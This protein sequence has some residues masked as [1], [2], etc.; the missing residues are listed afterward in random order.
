M[1]RWAVRVWPVGGRRV[2]P[3]VLHDTAA[4]CWQCGARSRTTCRR[5]RRVRGSCRRLSPDRHDPSVTPRRECCWAG[6]DGLNPGTASPSTGATSPRRPAPDTLSCDWSG[7]PLP[8]RQSGGNPFVTV[9]TSV[10]QADTC[11]GV[12]SDGDHRHVRARSRWIPSLGPDDRRL[13]RSVRV[14]AA[15]RLG[16]HAGGWARRTPNA[17]LGAQVH[18]SR[19]CGVIAT[20]R[21]RSNNARY[22]R[23]MAGG[24]LTRPRRGRRRVVDE[25]GTDRQPCPRP[26][27][28]G[29]AD[30]IVSKRG[31]RRCP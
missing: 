19:R 21:V 22:R 2:R 9:G 17:D 30:P 16:V 3:R 7:R 1:N 27:T 4:W 13:R 29:G 24:R 8:T 28:G 23:S 12:D 25:P 6:R 11:T 10:D 15:L 14:L 18:S 20:G 26:A 31:A 5:G